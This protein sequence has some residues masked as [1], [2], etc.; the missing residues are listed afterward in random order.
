[1][2]SLY[3]RV[4][5]CFGTRTYKFVKVS[6]IGIRPLPGLQ[7]VEHLSICLSIRFVCMLPDD[8]SFSVI[9]Y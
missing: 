6:I 4:Q 8:K 1:M 2:T 9:T 5:V 7:V 3:F